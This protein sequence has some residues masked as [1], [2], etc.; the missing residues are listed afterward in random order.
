MPDEHS[1]MRPIKWDRGLR[2]AQAMLAPSGIDG[3]DAER[4]RLRPGAGRPS[5]EKGSRALEI[6]VRRAKMRRSL[7]MG[8]R[9]KGSSM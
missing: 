1:G 3:N 4:R 7:V 9:S 8:A 2:E 6:R 5:Q